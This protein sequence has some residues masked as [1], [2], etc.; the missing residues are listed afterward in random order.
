[1]SLYQLRESGIGLAIDDFGTGFSSVSYLKR[2]PVSSV[3]IDKYFV[4]GL[5]VDP[6]DEDIISAIIAM[7]HSMHL[8]VVA[9]GVETKQQFE[10]LRSV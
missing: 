7:A 2:L 10:F 8:T 1:M 5:T 9:E 4:D 6:V 3:K